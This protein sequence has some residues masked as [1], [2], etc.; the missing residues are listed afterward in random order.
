MTRDDW[1]AFWMALACSSFL[2]AVIG[3]AAWTRLA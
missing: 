3:W 2:W 1:R